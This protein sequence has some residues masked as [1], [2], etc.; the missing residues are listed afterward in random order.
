MA[1]SHPVLTISRHFFIGFVCFFSTF[2]LWFFCLL[3]IRLLKYFFLL[4]CFSFSLSF[5]TPSISFLSFSSLYALRLLLNPFHSVFL[6]V[7]SS[8]PQNSF[9][10]NSAAQRNPQR[11]IFSF[12]FF[13]TQVQVK[14]LNQSLSGVLC[15]AEKRSVFL[16]SEKSTTFL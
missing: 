11:R 13:S 9:S 12:H 15:I 6:C 14:N 16:F 4:L 7:L 5:C 1:G 3:F 10:L 2:P 8:M